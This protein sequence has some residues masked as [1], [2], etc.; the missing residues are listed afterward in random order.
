MFFSHLTTVE[1]IKKKYRDLCKQ[2]HPDLG[3]CEETMKR[4]N[5]EYHCALKRA[6]GQ[7]SKDAEGKEHKYS[8]N[9]VREEEI[10]LKLQELLKLKME[11]VDLYLIGVWVWIKGETKPHK[12]ALKALACRWHAKNACWYYRPE[13]FKTFSSG[14][15]LDE[16]ARKYGA[17]RIYDT[18]DSKTGALAG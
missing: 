3:G 14:K 15:G 12:D 18:D 7:T 8:Y 13:G 9:E 2:H 1:E 16:L 5:S 10:A 11:G 4:V 6:D 17:R